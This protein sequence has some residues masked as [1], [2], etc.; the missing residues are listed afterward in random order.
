MKI[1]AGIHQLLPGL[2]PYWKLARG[3]FV[4]LLVYFG[5]RFT[6][7][8]AMP[9]IERAISKKSGAHSKQTMTL[10]KMLV[11]LFVWIITLTVLLDNLGIRVSALITGLGI[12]GIAIALAAQTILGD[13]FSYFIIFFDRPFELGDLIV[14]ND[15]RGTVENIGIKTTRLR[16]LDGEELVFSNTDLTSS[17]VRNYKRMHLRRIVFQLNIEYQTPLEK[18]REIPSILAAIIRGCQQAS[19]DRA[20]FAEYSQSALVFEVVYY[21]LSNDYTRYMDIQQEINFQIKE[22]FTQ[23]DIR[24]AYPT[25]TIFLK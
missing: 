22:A 2:D 1:L 24:F 9:L 19:F 15:F 8:I 5:V 10:I 7:K 17:R 13:L 12:G 14:I 3:V 11:Q 6:L 25:Q 21:V 18:L 20:H 16:S 23:K 4:I